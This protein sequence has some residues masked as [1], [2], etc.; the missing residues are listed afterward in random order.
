MAKINAVSR[1]PVGEGSGIRDKR[2]APRCAASTLGGG[3]GTPESCAPESRR[4]AVW[5]SWSVGKVREKA[6]THVHSCNHPLETQRILAPQWKWGNPR[7]KEGKKKKGSG[8]TAP[9]DSLQPKL[10]PR[11]RSKPCCAGGKTQ[12]HR[13]QGGGEATMASAR[14]PE[15][16][17]QNPLFR[18]SGSEKLSFLSEVQG[19][20]APGRLSLVQSWQ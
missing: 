14:R 3:L 20:K 8:R 15:A 13:E 12:P 4:W 19:L 11:L 1:Q 7:K 10:G 18:G 6:R 2:R 16:T 9:Q 5:G 17:I